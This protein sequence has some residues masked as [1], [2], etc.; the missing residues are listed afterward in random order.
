MP[1]ETPRPLRKPISALRVPVLIALASGCSATDARAGWPFAWDLAGR[2]DTPVAAL[3]TD[4]GG[5]QVLALAYAVGEPSPRSVLLEIGADGGLRWTREVTGPNAVALA[6]GPEG[7]TAVLSRAASQF[8]LSTVDAT[9][10]L[11]WSRTRSDLSPKEA[12]FGRSAGP[13]WDAQAGA[14]RVPAGRAGDFVVLSFAPDGT[15]LPDL[16]WSPP[17]GDGSASSVLPRPSGGLLVAGTVDST[18]PGWWIVAF[19]AAGVEQWRRFEDGGTAAG[20]FSG[21]FLLQADPVLAWADDESTC[22]LFS[23][24][25]WSLAAA[26]GAPRWARSWPETGA[27]PACDSFQP[28]AAVLDGGAV[29]AAGRGDAPTGGS[30]FDAVV[31]R[32]DAASGAPTWARA[33]TGTSTTIESFATPTPSGVLLAASLFPP[34]NPGPVPHWA[35]AWDTSGTP[36]AAPR[37][38]ADSR[39]VALVPGADTVF[40]VGYAAA[41]VT[42]GSGDDVLVQRVDD[43]CAGRFGDGFE[44][45]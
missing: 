12:F 2:S 41:R 21:A 44:P 22:G 43:P 28:S 39:G 9:G 16:T 11:Q 10:Q 25:L 3:S 33:Y 14:W 1:T 35:V 36:C 45:R 18:P 20:V 17:Q 19:D 40:V 24:R 13:A 6:R 4:D 7:S 23:L 27:P 34:V 32:F 31:L 37:R 26:D 15:P 30:G 42:T 5:L 38:L 29:V 8:A